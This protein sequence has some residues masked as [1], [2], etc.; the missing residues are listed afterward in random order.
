MFEKKMLPEFGFKEVFK[1]DET[2]VS[3]LIELAKKGDSDAWQTLLFSMKP[4]E[5][6]A[7]F[8]KMTKR[9]MYKLRNEFLAEEVVQEV[10]TDMF[11]GIANYRSESTFTTWCYTILNIKIR[12]KQKELSK[13][14][15]YDQVREYLILNR[16]LITSDSNIKYYYEL[17][18]II[19]N[20][21]YHG[22]KINTEQIKPLLEKISK[23]INDSSIKDKLS[24]WANDID[25]KLYGVRNALGAGTGG[26]EDDTSEDESSNIEDTID[27]S[28]DNSLNHKQILQKIEFLIHIKFLPPSRE[29]DI[30]YMKAQGIAQ[31]EIANALGLTDERIS[32]IWKKV[33]SI[34]KNEFR[35]L[36]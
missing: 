17:I 32:A 1:Y 19:E 10:V 2:P 33:T 22:V 9:A 23:N 28:P 13:E 3:T 21:K 7:L 25:K 16:K 14:V 6:V 18:S 30:L 4:F 34:L 20:D 15:N 31:T 8:K 29:A 36:Y 26:E 24:K 5:S 35:G 27:N 12:A 11:T